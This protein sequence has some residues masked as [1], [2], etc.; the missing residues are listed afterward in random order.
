MMSD[1]CRSRVAVRVIVC[2]LL[3]VVAAVLLR[4]ASVTRV[5]VSVCR[6]INHGG[7]MYLEF[8]MRGAG[9]VSLFRMGESS[10]QFCIGLDQRIPLGEGEVY[11]RYL[12]SD[13]VERR[14]HLGYVSGLPLSSFRRRVVFDESDRP[15]LR[16]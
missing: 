8:P 1:M 16:E 12:D 9:G 14:M 2:V 15:R 4:S 5:A 3:V 6:R 7:A 10:G 11:L 13:G